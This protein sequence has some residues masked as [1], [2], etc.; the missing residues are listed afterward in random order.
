M[1]LPKR[2]KAAPMGVRVSDRVRSPGH[3]SWLRGFT[4]L[5]FGR[6]PDGCEGPIEAHHVSEDGNAGTG[7]KAP[8][9]D[10]VPLCAT[11]H[12]LGHAIGWGTF[13]G[14]YGVDLLA[15]AARFWRI[16]PHRKKW[17]DRDK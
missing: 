16:S 13:A 4:C 14:R 5:A 12:A 6:D 3:L 9:S 2:R 17:E 8:D 11:H 10:A 15:A 1:A 7:I